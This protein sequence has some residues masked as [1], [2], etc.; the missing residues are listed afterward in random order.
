MGSAP[1]RGWWDRLTTS[2]DYDAGTASYYY[3]A[4]GN[5]VEILPP[6]AT[7]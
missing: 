4:I 7:V 2:F 3:D 5:L 6:G 1:H